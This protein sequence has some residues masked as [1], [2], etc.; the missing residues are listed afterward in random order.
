MIRN[1]FY[2]FL[3]REKTFIISRKVLEV[4]KLPFRR[5][6]DYLALS[7]P[8]EPVRALHARLEKLAGLKLHTRE[9][10][11]VTVIT[12]PE[13]E[14]LKTKLKMEEIEAI[15]LRE[16]IQDADL[17]LLCIGEG[18]LQTDEGEKKT[19]FIVVKS[20]RLMRIRKSIELLFRARGGG[21]SEFI[22]AN[23]YPHITIGFTDTDLHFEQGVVKDIRS[24]RYRLRV[25]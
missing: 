17:K 23:Y 12:P 5:H 18:R 9:E 6:E 1:L 11:H 3:R 7:V 2:F 20:R 25:E 8:F 19:Y 15:A 16:Q 21:R 22:A 10:S 24:C 14:I 13:L 4:Q